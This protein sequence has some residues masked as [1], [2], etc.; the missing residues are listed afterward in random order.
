MERIEEDL[1]KP[2]DVGGK[3]VFVALSAGIVLSSNKE[4]PAELLR[5][6]DLAMYS[7]KSHGKAR[8]EVYDPRMDVWA[9]KRVDLEGD[10]R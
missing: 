9:Q 5:H 6:A 10:L 1:Q 4:Q 3:Q 2:V 8:Y 7:A